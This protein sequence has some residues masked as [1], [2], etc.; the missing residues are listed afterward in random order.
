MLRTLMLA[1]ATLALLM[2]GTAFAQMPMPSISLGGD[3][4]PLTPEERARQDA[5]DKAYKSSLTKIPTRNAASDPWAGVRE[6]PA[7]RSK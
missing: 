3:K 5:I 4:P 1:G 6:A 2:T 7:T